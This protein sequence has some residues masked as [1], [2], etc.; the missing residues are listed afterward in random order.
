M[1]QQR[2]KLSRGSPSPAPGTIIASNDVGIRRPILLQHL[3]YGLWQLKK[4][5]ESRKH[6]LQS[7]DGEGCGNML[8][9]FHLCRGFNTELDLFITQ[10]VLQYL[11]LKKVLEAATA[12]R[13]YTKH[14]PNIKMDP[15]F[16]H[17]L[18][19]FLWLLIISIKVTVVAIRLV[20]LS[21]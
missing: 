15:P 1:V 20:G 8:V 18:L 2:H 11:C 21:V 13:A 12:F 5:A 6:F 17:P 16:S 3:A 7:G 14:H 19:N 10:T 9:E 4:Y